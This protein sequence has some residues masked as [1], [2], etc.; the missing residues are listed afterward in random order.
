MRSNQLSYAPSRRCLIIIQQNFPEGNPRAKEILAKG[1][2]PVFEPEPRGKTR[3][4]S[5]KE[6]PVDIE[7]IAPRDD[8]RRAAGEG[9]DV[10]V[11]G[12]RPGAVGGKRDR[13]GAGGAG[14]VDAAGEG[15]FVLHRQVQRG[16]R[17]DIDLARHRLA[18]GGHHHIAA[19]GTRGA[20]AAAAAV[21]FHAQQRAVRG[22]ERYAGQV[23]RAARVGHIEK[24]AGRRGQAAAGHRKRVSEPSAAP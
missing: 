13:H 14:A 1:R 18:V 17:V 12:Q 24:I 23:D 21:A 8:V 20:P 9:G 7:V 2:A 19:V 10:A 5:H 11:R 6:R 4:A 22:L 3:P 16:D 15:G